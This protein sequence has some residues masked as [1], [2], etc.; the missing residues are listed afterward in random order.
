MILL[1]SQQLLKV[2]PVSA[3]Y[4]DELWSFVVY[5]FNMNYTIENFRKSYANYIKKQ[6]TKV[7]DDLLRTLGYSEEDILKN[8]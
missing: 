4:Q 2:C 3:D 5:E 1:L 7:S 8:Y 6:E